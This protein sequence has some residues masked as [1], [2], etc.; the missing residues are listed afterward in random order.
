MDTIIALS[1]AIR[2]VVYLIGI[3]FVVGATIYESLRPSS[4]KP[5]VP[6]MNESE[7]KMAAMLLKAS[8]TSLDL[9]LAALEISAKMSEAADKRRESKE[10]YDVCAAQRIGETPGT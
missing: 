8:E 9:D 1:K 6:I 2:I 5:S 7:R 3:I 4:H 10:S